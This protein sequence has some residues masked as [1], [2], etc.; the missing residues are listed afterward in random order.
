VLMLN[1]WVMLK[2]NSCVFKTS[3]SFYRMLPLWDLPNLSVFATSQ[4]ECIFRSLTIKGFE[5]EVGYLN[6][7][8][9]FN[10]LHKE[11]CHLQRT[12]TSC[13]TYI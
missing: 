8:C 2:V 12:F 1:W 11:F 7:G 13:F 6:H 5:G 9:D 4:R 10:F 3:N